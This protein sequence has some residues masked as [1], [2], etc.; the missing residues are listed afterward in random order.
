MEQKLLNSILKQNSTVE[1]TVA[2][3]LGFSDKLLEVTDELDHKNTERKNCCSGM[4]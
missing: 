2:F 1:E 3:V 4:F